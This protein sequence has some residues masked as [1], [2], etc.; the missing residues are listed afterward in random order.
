M[1]E[2]FSRKLFEELRRL[3]KLLNHGYEL[4]V[5]WLPKVKRTEKNGKYRV[6]GE[7]IGK[8]IYIYDE[9]EDEAVKT[10]RHEIIEH[11]L[12]TYEKSYVQFINYLIK[13]FNEVQRTKREKFV[14]KIAKC[15]D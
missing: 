14:E 15:I 13:F 2:I 3:Q 4:E 11:L 6:C 7:I 8:T 12:Y 10:L 5:K 1:R 9:D